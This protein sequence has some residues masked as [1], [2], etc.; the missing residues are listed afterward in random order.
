MLS[1]GLP[2]WLL[3]N[4]SVGGIKWTQYFAMMWC[5]SVALNKKT[6]IGSNDKTC[7]K[8]TKIHIF[9]YK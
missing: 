6:V 1:A 5:N 3:G 7:I 2:I 4:S 8:L 9:R